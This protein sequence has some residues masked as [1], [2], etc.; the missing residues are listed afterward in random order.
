M[1][2]MLPS[3]MGSYRRVVLV[4][5]LLVLR[6]LDGS[7]ATIDN[8]TGAVRE[9]ALPSGEVPTVAIDQSSTIATANKGEATTTTTTSPIS[10]TSVAISTITTTTT[11]LPSM[12]VSSIEPTHQ[13][14]G[15]SSTTGS[16][17]PDGDFPA[18][19]SEFSPSRVQLVYSEKA[20]IRKCCPPGQMIQPRQ[21]SQYECVPGS[22]ELQIETVE[23][24]FYGNNECIEVSGESVVLPVESQDLCD[25][26]PNALMYSADQGDELFVLQN[27][28]LLVL[29]IGTLVSVFDSY[30]VE[31]TS[32][33]Q[34]LAKVCED[35]RTERVGLE[36][37]F[38]L[39]G[40]LLSVTT[41]LFTALCYSFVEKLKGTFGYL[42]AF[43]A[44]AF[45]IGTI[46]FGL[47]RCGGRCINP[48]HVGITDVLSNALLGSSF[49]A[50]CLMNIYNTMYVAYYIP[51]GLE[52]ENKNKRDM[53]AALAVMYCITLIPLFLLPKGG[54]ICVV[55]ISLGVI[56]ISQALYTYY[57]RRLTSGFYQS[58]NNSETKIN[59]S[60][61]KDIGSQR[62]T[63]LMEALCALV[64][65]IV[66]TVLILTTNLDGAARIF[67]FYCVVGQG[68]TIGTLYVIGQQWRI[69]LRECWS[70]SGSRDLR[71]EENDA[72]TE[73]KPLE[74]NGH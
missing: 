49:F 66:L 9:N 64:V 16:T 46:F 8:A 37:F 13:A 43:H 35:G 36:K 25:G 22:R 17:H 61:L 55:F 38:M 1:C 10:T 3:A 23:A 32:D 59:Q 19:C 12:E 14:V 33:A 18:N 65:W 30:C 53:Y 56:A 72:G 52:F 4:L 7:Y 20:R 2:V 6:A 47:A 58:I 62:Q 31:M 67:A 40:T 5:I 50:F 24:H 48:A 39:F 69:I 29:E 70:N 57:R 60:R 63:C 11:T 45:A 73:L 51:N 21:N 28:S 34:L 26:E 27:G 68:L 44:G 74:S 41:L 15:P 42:V 71:A 54:L